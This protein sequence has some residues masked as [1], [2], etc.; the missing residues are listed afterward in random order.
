MLLFTKFCSVSLVYTGNITTKR[1][2]QFCLMWLC[3]SHYA[4]V[5]VFTLVAK[6]SAWSV[7]HGSAVVLLCQKCEPNL[8]VKKVKG[9]EV[10][11]NG[12]QILWPAFLV[13]Q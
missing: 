5:V 12:M 1:K 3:L 6:T 10:V 9:S 4:T 13:S 2:E 7:L 8:R 11:R